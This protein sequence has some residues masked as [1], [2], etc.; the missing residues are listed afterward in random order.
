MWN[1]GMEKDGIKG[2][3]YNKGGMRWHMGGWD[4]KSG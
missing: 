1:K 3:R 2:L 4:K